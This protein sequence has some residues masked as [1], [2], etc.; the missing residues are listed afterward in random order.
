MDEADDSGRNSSDVI[1]VTEDLNKCAVCLEEIDP[2]G[3][4]EWLFYN[5]CCGNAIHFPC[6]QQCLN[7]NITKCPTC[8]SHFTAFVPFNDDLIL[9]PPP[10]LASRE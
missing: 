4:Q 3:R 2:K 5:G 8:S 6:Y 7:S 10:I 9:P 1:V